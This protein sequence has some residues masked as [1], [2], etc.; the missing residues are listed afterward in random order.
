MTCHDMSWCGQSD[1]ERHA[2]THIKTST[3]HGYLSLANVSLQMFTFGHIFIFTFSMHIN[4]F[5]YWMVDAFAKKS[6][7][8]FD[9]I[10]C[11]ISHVVIR[12]PASGRLSCS[13][14][15]FQQYNY[16]SGDKANPKTSMSLYDD[17][18]SLYFVTFI[19][20][21]SWPWGKH[22]VVGWM[23]HFTHIAWSKTFSTVRGAPKAP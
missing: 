10:W 22:F 23:A 3:K 20:V 14:Q 7:V 5:G 21:T 11:R 17:M 1:S 16:S 4:F 12:K 13:N 9:K 6:C 15:W 2:F 18:Q 19:R 8:R